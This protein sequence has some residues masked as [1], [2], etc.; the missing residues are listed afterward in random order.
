MAV[1]ARPSPAEAGEGAAR[2]SP[3]AEAEGAALRSLEAEKGV[4][5]PF[6][7]VGAAAEPSR[8][9]EE[10]GARAEEEVVLILTCRE[11]SF[12]CNH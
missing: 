10:A 2:R 7:T 3:G 9:A 5:V 1:P 6:Q 12:V 4:V 11:R 8:A